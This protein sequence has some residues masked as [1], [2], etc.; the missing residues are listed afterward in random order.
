M[1]Q[2]CGCFLFFPHFFRLVS[3]PF[4]SAKFFSTMKTAA[5]AS[6]IRTEGCKD[7]LAWLS[8]KLV[9]G[10]SGTDHPKNISQQE[11]PSSQG[12][13][14]LPR[15]PALVLAHPPAGHEVAL[16]QGQRVRLHL[17]AALATL[18]KELH[19]GDDLTLSLTHTHTKKKK[20]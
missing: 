2:G 7:T 5:T 20:K 18:A 14:R 10:T 8:A 11:L 1:L 12:L 6:E 19:S 4:S 15:H 13:Q 16:Q 17:D 3:N 9:L